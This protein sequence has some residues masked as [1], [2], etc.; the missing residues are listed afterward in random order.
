MLSSCNAEGLVKYRSGY[1]PVG[2]MI[3]RELIDDGWSDLDS[4]SCHYLSD[5]ESSAN[6]LTS[7]FCPHAFP[8]HNII[9]IIYFLKM[10]VEGGLPLSIS[11]FN[12]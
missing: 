1:S 9:S 7:T 5:P 6:V 4:R 3:W 11:L 10:M 2:Y 12:E 8:T